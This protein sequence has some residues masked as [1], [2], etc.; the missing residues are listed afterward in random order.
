MVFAAG[1]D[2]IAQVVLVRYLSKADFGAWSY[3]LAVIAL[4]SMVAQLEM[5]NTVARFLPIYAERRQLGRARGA[6]ALSLLIVTGFGIAL[7]VALFFAIWMFGLRPID[8]PTALRLLV[9]IAVLIPIL[10]L[11]ALFT[12]LFA[13]FG[14][15]RT[16]FFR[17]SVLN[18]GLRLAVVLLLIAMGADID[19]LAVAYVTV[20]IA[21][22]VLYAANLPRVLRQTTDR[23]GEAAHS[24]EFP[25]RELLRYSTPLLASTVVWILM[26]SSDALLLG[27]FF[28]AE[29]VASYRIVAPLAHM[30][31]FAFWAFTTL[32]TPSA[33]RA[34][35]RSD[36]AELRQLYWQTAL[37]M[38]VLTFPI[39]VLTSSFASVVVP[40]A[41]GSEYAGS[42]P[43][44]AL[45]SIGFFFNTA[46]GFNGLTL[47]V[48]HRLRYM[49]AVD[50][51]MALLN[52]LV[53]LALI[54]RFGPIGAAAGT[55]GTVILHTLLK[56]VGLWR[57]TG[58]TIFPMAYVPVYA[59]LIGL[60]AVLYV[61]NAAFSANLP[62]AV[63]LSG[64]AALA[65]IALA[66]G[67]LQVDVLFPELAGVP[68]LRRL[69]GARP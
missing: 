17:H 40:S 50:L 25:A 62:L 19:F 59:G 3:A 31:L 58:V 4:L 33:A 41:Y 65:A 54:P 47:R 23:A 2:F 66:R 37:W 32:F 69:T 7:A 61:I 42:A 56:H 49:V 15:S 43:I 12:G 21:G 20:S 39:F 16:I 13:A 6:I 57:F 22:L 67:R 24:R 1:V 63:V 55:T 44:L 38:T 28:D 29:A 5:G 26:D 46:L 45:L 51:S 10:A 11:D 14:A 18:P 36:T 30:N 8:D 64:T 52:I 60:A 9:L 48:H 34:F 27:Y 68:F 35:A 53:N